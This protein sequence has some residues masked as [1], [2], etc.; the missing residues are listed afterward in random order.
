MAKPI[1][2]TVSPLVAADWLATVTPQRQAEAAQLLHIFTAETGFQPQLWPG[3]IVGFGRY[4]YR[5]ASGHAGES[6]AAGF[7]PRK[8]D[9]SIYIMPGDADHAALCADLG[10]HRMGKG[11]LYLR[12]LADADEGALRA[13]I[14]AGLNDLMAKWPVRAA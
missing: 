8:A 5:Y 4:T 13:L 9:L 10:R 12:R 14:R 2:P 3:G 1:L 7:A 6:L 11:C